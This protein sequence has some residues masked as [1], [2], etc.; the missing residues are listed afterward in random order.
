[1]PPITNMYLWQPIAAA[2][3]APCVDGDYDMSVI[4]HEYTHAISNRMAG[5]PNMGLSGSQ[6]GAMGESWSDLDAV[7]YLNENGYVPTAGENPFAVGPYVTGDHQAGIR[8]YGMN[9]SPLNYSDV[10]YDFAC[11]DP[12]CAAQTQV[13]ADGE[14]WSATNYDVRQAFVGRYGSGSAALQTACAAG[15]QPV[16]ACPG[17]RRWIQLMYDAWLLM[18]TGAV[19]M[20]DARNA[21]LAADQIRFNGINQDILW[22]AFAKRGLGQGASSNTASDTDPVPSFDSPFA[23]EATVRFRPTG[24]AAGATAQLFVGRYEARATPIADTD[25]STARSDTFKLVPGTYEL[26][27]RAGGFGAQ[28]ISLTVSAGQLRD[29]TVSMREN[30]ASAANGATTTGD[31]VNQ[32]ALIDDTEATNWASLGSPVAGKQVTVRL[33]PSTPASTFRRVQVSALLRSRLPN[34]AGGDTAAQNRF[35]ALRQFEVL[36]CQARGAVDCTQDSQFHVVLT[37]AAGPVPVRRPAPASAGDAHAVVRRSADAGQPR[38]AAGADQPVHRGARLSGRPGRR[39]AEH[40]RLQR[41][42]R[43]GRDRPRRGTAGVR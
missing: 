30:F 15:S 21:M 26:V 38:A 3:Y 4:A 1:M 37:S 35:S 5:G 34:D 32:G 28:R 31:G 14:I 27:A 9:N 16:T 24:D 7:E 23:D 20:V 10:G 11:N 40:H 17:N 12:N 36:A 39:S 43:A 22:N 8:N 6:A 2:F 41:G 33:D 42:Q 25:P 29:L 13:H 18:P 19:S